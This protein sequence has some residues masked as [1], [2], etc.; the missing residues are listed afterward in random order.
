MSIEK[1]EI[2]T[3][4][5]VPDFPR[6]DKVK[7]FIL[8]KN[9]ISIK[10][11]INILELGYSK[12]GLLDNL[13]E[14]DN[15]N[16]FA[17]DL[18]N[19]KTPEEIT[20]YKH[21]IN[22]GLPDFNS[23]KFDIIFAGEVIEHIIDDEKFLKDIYN[24]LN[25]KGLL[26][27]T[28]PNLFFLL[29][30]FLLFFGKMPYFAYEIYHYHFYSVETLSKIVLQSGFKI[31]LVQSSHLLFSRRRNKLFGRIFEYLGDLFPT[32]GAHIILYAEKK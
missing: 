1:Q 19:K 32:F 3:D 15:L 8:E 11:N 5:L 12:G 26:I 14:Y 30:R 25:N 6:I 16:K 13:K 7:K 2:F 27:L 22:K 10:A 4:F 17:L 28:T 9:Y 31:N 24:I 18:F 23:T 20:Y 21:D 29:N